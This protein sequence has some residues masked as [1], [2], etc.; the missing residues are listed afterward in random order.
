MVTNSEAARQLAALRKRKERIC[1]VCGTMFDAFGKQ[2]YDR[3]AC[4]N[5]ASYRKVGRKGRRP[6]EE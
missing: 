4:A 6:P 5:K 1:P 2:K 3:K